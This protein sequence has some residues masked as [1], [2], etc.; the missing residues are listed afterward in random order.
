MLYNICFLAVLFFIYSVIGYIAEVIYVSITEKR[1]AISRG[2]LI[3]PYLPI[4]AA[5]ILSMV[6]LLNKYKDDLFILFFMSVVICSFIEYMTSYVMEKLF[7]LRWW[8]YSNFKFNI[9]GRICLI[10]SALFG[11]AGVFGVRYLNPFMCDLVSKLSNTTIIVLGIMFITILF[12]D[13]VI[14]NCVICKLK[15]D[16][17]LF[18]NKDATTKVREEVM[19]SLDKYRVLNIRLFNA[20]PNI[21]KSEPIK[22]ITTSFDK[23][24]NKLIIKDLKGKIKELKKKR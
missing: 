2:F 10:N 1:F 15:I 13:L 8:D 11:I 6:F 5:G 18:I 23:Y 3:G 20:F 21:L 4:Y 9:N 19:K 7:H 16:T 24:K 17:S 14:S 22:I 12:V